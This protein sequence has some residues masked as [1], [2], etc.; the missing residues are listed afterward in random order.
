MRSC[1]TRIPG[2]EPCPGILLAVLNHKSLWAGA[3]RAEAMFYGAQVWDPALIIAQIVTLQCL[4]YLSLGALLFLFVGA[5][6]IVLRLCCSA[7]F[8]AFGGRFACS[9][10]IICYCP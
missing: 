10:P 4:F 6:L 2:T 8:S 1:L 9:A 3:S 5:P 7:R